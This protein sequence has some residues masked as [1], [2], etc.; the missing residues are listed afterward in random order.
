M[1]YRLK[2]DG[3]YISDENNFVT[4]EQLSQ[5]TLSIEANSSTIFELEWQWQHNDAT[6]TVA[7]ENSATYSLHIAFTAWVKR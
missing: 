6:D 7:G 5:Q 2:R 4:A 3:A 1:L